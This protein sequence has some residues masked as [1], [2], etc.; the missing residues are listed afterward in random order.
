VQGT[1]AV[2]PLAGTRVTI[3]DLAPTVDSYNLT[4]CEILPAAK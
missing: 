4:I 3:N 2:V 1:S